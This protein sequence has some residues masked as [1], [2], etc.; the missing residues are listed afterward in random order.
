MANAARY[1]RFRLKADVGRVGV[2][3]LLALSEG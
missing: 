1:L 3:F 2:M